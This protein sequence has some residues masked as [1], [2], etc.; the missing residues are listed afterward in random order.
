MRLIIIIGLCILLVG[1][2]FPLQNSIYCQ[3]CRAN[4]GININ[5]PEINFTNM[6]CY[7]ND[8]PQAKNN[9]KLCTCTYMVKCYHEG[10]KTGSS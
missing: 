7:P 8:C 9:P 6:C 5:V 3:E 1:C 4:C 10:T 2:E